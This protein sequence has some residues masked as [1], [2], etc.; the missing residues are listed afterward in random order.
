MDDGEE[1]QFVV[2]GLQELE[3]DRF[4]RTIFAAGQPNKH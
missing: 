3:D 1:L 4:A 2:N